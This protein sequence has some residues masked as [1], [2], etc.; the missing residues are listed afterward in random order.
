[1][2]MCIFLIGVLSFSLSMFYLGYKDELVKFNKQ[3]KIRQ[4][5]EAETQTT[6]VVHFTP[7]D[8]DS[9]PTRDIDDSFR[10]K[11]FIHLGAMVFIILS[12]I[13]L[14]IVL[15]KGKRNINA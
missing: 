7:E 13:G 14:L 2:I 5:K 15:P 3:E 9:N 4:E 1:M 10:T 12:E 11:L 8:F 6:G